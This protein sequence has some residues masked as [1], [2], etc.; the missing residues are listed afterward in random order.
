M[1]GTKKCITSTNFPLLHRL[2]NTRTCNNVRIDFRTFFQIVVV[3]LS[4]PSCISK[5][6][7]KKRSKRVKILSILKRNRLR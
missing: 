3:F 6:I 7:K 2:L 1:K 4:T 5:N